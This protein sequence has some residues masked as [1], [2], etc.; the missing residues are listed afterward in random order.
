MTVTEMLTDFDPADHLSSDRATV[1]FMS[2]ALETNDPAYIAHCLG[3][4]AR[5]RGLT[6]TER[7][8]HPFSATDNPTLRAVLALLDTLGLRLVA[9]PAGE[10]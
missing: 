4:V 8:T 1:A 5:A 2:D 7:Q 10:V 9:K 6:G 3:I